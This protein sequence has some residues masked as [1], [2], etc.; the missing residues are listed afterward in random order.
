MNGVCHQFLAGSRL[1]SDQHGAFQGVPELA[2]I[3]RPGMPDE[4]GCAIGRQP[5]PRVPQSGQGSAQAVTKILVSTNLV[6]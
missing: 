6:M 5:R 2:H 1:T 3:P 4:T